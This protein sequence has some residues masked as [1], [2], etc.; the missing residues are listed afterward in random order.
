MRDP[1]SLAPRDIELT[2]ELLSALDSPLRLQILLLLNSGDHVVHEMV[3]ELG[4][5]QPLISQHLRVLKGTGLVRPRRVGREVIYSLAQPAI[6]DVILELAVL[7]AGGELD[8][9]RA[10]RAAEA[11][12]GS[13]QASASSATGA[14]II[15][16]PAYVR[17]EL[18]PGLAPRTPRPQKD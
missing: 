1:N 2:A 11:P 9:R 14:A 10:A 16:P 7:A 5:S 18:D 4:K 12:S 13:S 15:K 6:I 8:R 17:P 3:N